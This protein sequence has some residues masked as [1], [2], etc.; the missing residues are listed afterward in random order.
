MQGR[1]DS[2]TQGCKDVRTQEHGDVRTRGLEDARTQGLV[3]YLHCIHYLQ[4]N[5]ILQFDIIEFIEF[6]RSL[7][8]ALSQV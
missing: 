4:Y 3:I 2:R 7:E 8:A 5:F 1:K 6:S